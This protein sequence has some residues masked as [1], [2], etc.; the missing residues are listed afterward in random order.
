MK[1]RKS[2]PGYILWVVYAMM[3]TAAMAQVIG[4]YIGKFSYEDGALIGAGV[5]ALVLTKLCSKWLLGRELLG[6]TQKKVLEYLC[7]AAILLIALLL[8]IRFITQESFTPLENEFFLSAAIGE[9]KQAFTPGNFGSYLY[10]SFLSFIMALWG[11][12]AMVGIYTQLILQVLTICFL[13][14]TVKNINGRGA[15]ILAAV[16]MA[17][18]G[19]GIRAC[20]VMEPSIMVLCLFMLVF[21]LITAACKASYSAA[22]FLWCQGLSFFLLGMLTA[23]LTAADITGVILFPI[24]FWMILLSS[25]RLKEKKPWLLSACYIAGTAAGLLLLS[26]SKLLTTKIFVIQEDAFRI[27]FLFPTTYLPAAVILLLAAGLWLV[28]IW[29]ADNDE[30]LPHVLVLAGAI[31]ACIF[32]NNGAQHRLILEISWLMAAAVGIKSLCVVYPAR[33]KAEVPSIAPP[34]SEPVRDASSVPKIE[35]VHLPPLPLKSDGQSVKLIDNP[36]PLPKKHIKKEMDYAFEPNEDQMH[37]DIN[38]LQDKDD[39]DIK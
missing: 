25:G 10:V 7:I 36:L 9:G 22:A 21:F 8:R 11:N 3:L 18:S 29:R 33:E 31:A 14:G 35:I 17:V 16:F 28:R 30:M 23:V 32:W 37:Y 5:I 4:A 38:N 27:P 24:A 2:V 13:F 1:L 20:G 39:Y 19:S 12:K 15:A 34:V 26:G 6:E